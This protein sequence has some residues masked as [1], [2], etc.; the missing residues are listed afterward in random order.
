MSWKC[1]ATSATAPNDDPSRKCCKL[2]IAK[3]GVGANITDKDGTV[4]ILSLNSCLALLY[5]SSD[6]SFYYIR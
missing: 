3:Y 6:C 1:Q 4:S 5:W 2:Q